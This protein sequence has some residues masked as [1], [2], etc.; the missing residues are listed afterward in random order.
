MIINYLQTKRHFSVSGNSTKS[1]IGV[2]SIRKI[3]LSF[4]TGENSLLISLINF[5]RFS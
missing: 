3:L 1:N 4:L 2:P 5:L